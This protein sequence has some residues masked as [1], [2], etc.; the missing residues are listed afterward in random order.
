MHRGDH[1]TRCPGERDDLDARQRAQRHDPVVPACERRR[2]RDHRLHG[3]H[4]R[5]PDRSRTGATSHTFT[6]LA[7]GTTY[8]LSVA[9]FNAVGT[10]PS[11]G[12]NATTR[13]YPGSATGVTGEQLSLEEATISWTGVDDDGNS[14][15]TDFE[16][17]IDGGGFI[18]AG[19]PSSTSY[20][21]TGL[22]GHEHELTVRPVNGIGNG[23]ETPSRRCST[24]LPARSATS[25]R[26]CGQPPGGGRH[27]EPADRDG[28]RPITEHKIFVDG[29][30]FASVPG[31][32]EGVTIENLERGSTYVIGVQAVNAE[33]DGPSSTVDAAIPAEKPTA[34][35]I[36]KAQGGEKGGKVTACSVASARHGQRCCHHEVQDPR[37]RD[38][39][40]KDRS[41]RLMTVGANKRA[42]AMRLSKGKWRFAVSARNAM[43]WSPWS[44]VSNTV[45]A[46]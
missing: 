4:R 26:V 37:R 29:V 23:D 1:R 40:Q 24:P 19:G 36:G 16:V 34:P 9:A 35:R 14:P 25:L 33:G 44:Q 30:S 42:Q 45:K 8:A 38:Q 18:S 13:D 12:S 5:D 3:E 46:R 2:E 39:G 41:K 17:S 22:T 6:G 43:G 21:F 10:G 31:D 32:A 27:L 28:G 11:A 7:P 20:T 15:I